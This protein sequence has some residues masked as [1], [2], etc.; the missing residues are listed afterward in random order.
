MKILC[1][2]VPIKLKTECSEKNSVLITGG[3]RMGKTFFASNFAEQLIKE[4]HNVHLIDLGEKWGK[5]DKA[6]LKR[7]GAVINRVESQG[8]KLIFS[9]VAE[10]A[11]CS[12]HIANALDIQSSEA[13]TI[14]KEILLEQ[15]NMGQDNLSMRKVFEVFESRCTKNTNEGKWDQKIYRRIGGCGNIPDIRFYV[16]ADRL[17]SDSSVIWELSGLD[18]RYIK[19][20]AYL[21]TYCLYCQQRQRFKNNNNVVKNTFVIIDEFQNLDCDRKSIIGI[22]LTE[23][24]KYHLALILITQFLRG[25]FSEAVINQ[26]KQGGFQFHFRPTEEEAMVMSRRFSI[27]Y[28]A[29]KTLYQKLINLPRGHCLMLGPHSVGNRKEISEKFRFVEIMEEKTEKIVAIVN[30]SSEKSGMVRGRCIAPKGM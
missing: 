9:S 28:D 25:N 2:N 1:S 30:T 7:A 5:N 12:E 16:E 24:Q 10:L 18:D 15:Y 11:G 6:R 29:Q 8:I 23:G 4:K 20:V 21:I 26:F 17:F 14:L 22:C 3:S 27:D 13:K 19:I